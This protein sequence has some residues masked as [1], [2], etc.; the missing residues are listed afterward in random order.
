MYRHFKDSH[1]AGRTPPASDV[2]LLPFTDN[3]LNRF[4][5][6]FIPCGDGTFAAH[7]DAAVMAA[8][9]TASYVD[10]SVMTMAPAAVHDDPSDGSVTAVDSKDKGKACK[11]SSTISS[12]EDPSNPIEQ[13]SSSSQSDRYNAKRSSANRRATV[14]TISAC[15]LHAVALR[16]DALTKWELDAMKD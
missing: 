12:V 5:T 16:L 7:V 6:T 3:P 13:I 15:D 8:T 1:S 14:L 11:R 2:T 9:P 10:A 4:K